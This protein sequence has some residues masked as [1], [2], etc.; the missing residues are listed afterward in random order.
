MGLE[1][2]VLSQL[3][4]TE[5]HP[6]TSDPGPTHITLDIAEQSMQRKAIVYD[7]TGD[8]HYDAASAL[9]KSMRGSDPDAAVYW[10]AR[11]LEA[12]EDP[13]FIARRIAILAS[14]DIG[15]ADPRAIQ[16]ASAC[17]DIVERIGMPEAQLTLGQAAIYMA[18]A[19]KSN[20]SALAIWGAMKDVREG[21]TIPVP[22]HLRDG[23]YAGS[24]RLDHGTGYK[25]AHDFPGG[26]VE[27]DYL[28][29]EKKYYEPTDRGYEA[30][31]QKRLA[32][33][34]KT[35][36]SSESTAS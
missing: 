36:A 23:H 29:V 25:Y 21:R 9:I 3:N 17:F 6:P 20:A 8:D 24:K 7:G 19:P 27:Q 1:V 26:V 18:L 28:G 31:L 2:A 4:A 13:R 5:P 10:V 16:I 35:P 32:F 12:G 22:K 34:R 15:N 11:M 33:L 14:E 30:E